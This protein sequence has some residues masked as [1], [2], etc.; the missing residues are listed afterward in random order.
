M[1]FNRY[2][3]R[4]RPIKKLGSNKWPRLIGGVLIVVMVVVYVGLTN[5]TA[6][7]GYRLRSLQEEA[8]KMEEENST[9][10]IRVA[11]AQ[12]LQRLESESTSLSLVPLDHTEFLTASITAVAAR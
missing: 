6:T 4:S 2:Y 10:E 1:I 9:L 7:Q 3:S 12:S 5:D 8:K 11:A